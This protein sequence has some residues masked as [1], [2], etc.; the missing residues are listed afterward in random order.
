MTEPAPLLLVSMGRAGD[1][2][3][4]AAADLAKIAAELD[5]PYRLLG[6]NAVTL[7]VAA[8]GVTD[9][10]A[11]ETA[12]ADFGTT[13]AVIADKRLVEALTA[14]GYEQVEGN[15]FVRRHVMPAIPAGDGTSKVTTRELAVDV[16]APSYR[17]V[18]VSSRTHGE[19]VVDEVPGLGWALARP[20]MSVPIRVTLT[21]G[22]ELSTTLLLP[23]VVAALCLKAYAYRGRFADRDAVDAWRLLETAAKAGITSATWPNGPTPDA[24][25]AVL[26]QFFGRP[27]AGGLAQATRDPATQAR[28]RALVLTVVGA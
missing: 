28:I 12:D 14:R 24:A 20:G 16:L 26:R 11:R 15:R 4:L 5:V 10:P 8:H 9:V 22:H 19:L 13:P 3:F 21:S 27:G 25:A 17:D 23:D 7:L 1:A 2:G 18:L 6:G